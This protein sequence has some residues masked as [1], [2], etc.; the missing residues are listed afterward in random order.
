MA[1]NSGVGMCLRCAAYV[2][3]AVLAMS[4]CANIIHGNIVEFGPRYVRP[5]SFSYWKLNETGMCVGIRPEGDILTDDFSHEYEPMPIII[6]Y[7]VCNKFSPNHFDRA[8]FTGIARNTYFPKIGQKYSH[9]IV[10]D[11]FVKRDTVFVSSRRWCD[12]DI[13]CSSDPWECTP[14]KKSNTCVIFN[15]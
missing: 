9:I 12:F 4:M 14:N 2:I 3:V 7:C 6:E 10:Y 5:C 15:I 13:Y 1:K 11:P 8:I